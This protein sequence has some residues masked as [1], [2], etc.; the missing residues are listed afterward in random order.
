MTFVEKMISTLVSSASGI[1]ND[2]VLP[3]ELRHLDV[4]IFRQINED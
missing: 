4:A 2:M 3:M 1:A